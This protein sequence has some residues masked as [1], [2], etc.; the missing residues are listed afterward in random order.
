MF[1]SP[2]IAK[3]NYLLII[4]VVFLFSCKNTEKSEQI[5]LNKISGNTPTDSRDTYAEISVKEGGFWEGR[6]YRGGDFQNTNE[7]EVPQE[8]TDHSDFIRYEGPGWENKQVGYRLYL[9]WRNAIDIFGKKTDT[10]VLHRVGEDG[11]GSYHD[12][13]PWGMDIL[14]AG[15]S[16]GLGGF[17]RFMNDSVAHFRNVGKTLAKVENKHSQSSVQLSY[18]DWATGDKMIDL[19]AELNIFSDDRYT[20]TVL[21]PS[22][23]IDGLCTGIVKF[24]NIPLIK[25]ENSESD[26]AFIATY[27]NQTLAGD[28]DKLGMAIFYRPDEVQQ[29][30]KGKDDHLLVFKPTSEDVT[31]YFVGA[32]EQEL[33]GVT[34]EDDFLR[35]LEETVKGLNQNQI[36]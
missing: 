28:E 4:L 7:L 33:N 13:A 17:G 6:Q 35:Y 34:T 1:K 9:D 18:Q 5:A 20:K 26:W 8:H 29:I 25:S 27:G 15:E 12:N 32:W 36:Q 19:D 24:D 23:E 16:L 22:E 21:T 14:K 3:T 30:V 11:F 10:L 2:R 31:Y